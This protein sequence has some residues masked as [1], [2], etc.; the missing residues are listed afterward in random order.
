MEASN[1]LGDD[2][3]TPME[4]DRMNGIG[5]AMDHDQ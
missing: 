5:M 1:E 2:G 4:A 3:E